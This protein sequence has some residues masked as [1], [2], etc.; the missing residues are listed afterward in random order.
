VY[1]HPIFRGRWQSIHDRTLHIASS[2]CFSISYSASVFYPLLLAYHRYVH[3]TELQIQIRKLASKIKT[4]K[5]G[6]DLPSQNTVY[7]LV[8]G[9]I[10]IAVIYCWGSNF[11]SRKLSPDTKFL[12]ELAS[13]ILDWAVCVP[14]IFLPLKLWGD[15]F[16]TRISVYQVITKEVFILD[17]V[18][19]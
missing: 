15:R 18:E 17:L 11:I 13:I 4:G 14:E 9:V 10:Q 7:T 19:R 1:I 3:T 5:V 8:L 12:S 6:I 16:L 2:T